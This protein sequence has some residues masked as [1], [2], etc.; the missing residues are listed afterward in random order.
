MSALAVDNVSHGFGAQQVLSRV[1]LSVEPGSFTV[2]LG[3]NGAGKT[4][5]I[6]LVTG[7]YNARHGDIRI[8]GHSIRRDPLPALASLGVVFQMPTLDLDMS[9][10]Q[11]MTYHGS[12]HGLSPR[13][14]R[15][16]A[17]VELG[18]LG[19]GDRRSD[20]VRALSGGLRRR[21]EIA[22]ALLHQPKFL[23]VDEATAGLDVA[24]RQL[25][26]DHVRSLCRAGLSVLWATHMLDEIDA[27]D[28]LVVL[29][30]GKVRWTGQARAIASDRTL[31]AAFLDLTG[32]AS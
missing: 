9:V 2:L 22:R 7:L 4:T 13:E 15:E 18:R 5:L 10:E 26:L 14:T 30:Q 20:K 3:P 19:V 23:I 16:R 17:G 27:S 1:N 25:L 31:E 11:N 21:V 12:L 32:G 28:Q 29:H 6:S 24:G 8:F